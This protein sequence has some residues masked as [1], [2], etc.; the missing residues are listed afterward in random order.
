VPWTLNGRLTGVDPWRA[1]NRLA[2]A[3]FR[4]AA[5]SS[6]TAN[7]DVYFLGDSIFEGFYASAVRNGLVERVRRGLQQRY[8]PATVAGGEGYLAPMSDGM[9]TPAPGP[10]TYGGTP[11]RPAP[12][13]D[14]NG[15][16]LSGRY[17]MLDSA[18]DWAEVTFYGD[19]FAIVYT[20]GSG[21]GTLGFSVDGGAVQTHVT[22]NATLQSGK[23]LVGGALTR[24]Q[25]TVRFTASAG[26]VIVD[27]ILALDGD[28]T[29]GVRVF[30]GGHAGYD[31]ADFPGAG[32][33]NDLFRNGGTTPDL[34]CIALGAND[35]ANGIT[36]AQ[37]EINLGNI[38]DK[39][40][41]S[42]A[43]SALSSI[44]LW[45]YHRRGNI[46]DVAWQAYVDAMERVAVA[47]G[48]AFLDSHDMLDAPP[49]TGSGATFTDSV[50]PNDAGHAAY[51]EALL[52]F[53]A[54]VGEVR[55]RVGDVV[56]TG[57]PSAT[58]VLHGD[59]VWRAVSSPATPAKGLYVVRTSGSQNIPAASFVLVGL[60]NVQRNDFGA[61]W[62][63]DPTNIFTVPEDGWYAA[64]GTVRV[65]D[66]LSPTISMGIGIGPVMGDNTDFV[67]QG[68][69]AATTSSARGVMQVNHLRY[70]TAGQ[71]IRLFIY[72]DGT[73]SITSAS[74]AIVQVKGV[75]GDPGPAGPAGGMTLDTP[76]TVTGT[77]TWTD[78]FGSATATVSGAGLSVTDGVT[79][80]DVTPTGVTTTGDVVGGTVWADQVRIGGSTVDS[81][82]VDGTSAS[83]WAA[84]LLFGDGTGWGIRF[85]RANGTDVFASLTDQGV[86]DTRLLHLSGGLGALGPQFVAG[87][88]TVSGGGAGTHHGV[89][90]VEPSSTLDDQ[91]GIIVRAPDSGWGVGQPYAE[92]MAFLVLDEN[93]N[94]RW[95]V[96]RNGGTGMTGGLH[97]SPGANGA[98][99]SGITQAAWIQPLVAGIVPV[100]A[101]AVGTATDVALFRSNG[102]TTN[103]LRVKGNYGTEVGDRMTIFGD[104]TSAYV[105]HN[106]Y[107]DGT[108]WRYLKAGRAMLW[109]LADAYGA[110]Y[111]APS[112]AAGGIISWVGTHAFSDLAFSVS[113][114][115]V[116]IANSATTPAA[117]SVAV[118]E[119]AL[120]SY[121]GRLYVKENA[122]APVALDA[123][124]AY[125]YSGAGLAITGTTLVTVISTDS[126]AAGTYAFEINGTYRGSA[127]TQGLRIALLVPGTP[128]QFILSLIAATS[129]TATSNAVGIA[130][131]GVVGAGTASGG[132]ASLPFQATGSFV[133]PTGGV[134]SFRAAS[135]TTGSITIDQGTY[136]RLTR[137][138]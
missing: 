30:N 74:L 41:A 71:Q 26:L 33:W 113:A 80:T 65:P 25:H 91:T 73:F 11:G 108:N 43:G 64:H 82:R 70:W 93:N 79:T 57:T 3:R 19:Q 50:H 75:K 4:T 52:D 36:A 77:K 96:D 17:V 48:C 105:M 94:V 103:Q 59:G 104:P 97:V 111:H 22:T 6:A 130:N 83:P 37:Y 20:Q 67:W 46:T 110:H 58:T 135:H 85:L 35:V 12:G 137:I 132:T 55:V 88:A 63:A 117:Q 133:T 66:A 68:K 47:K 7:C 29:T 53:L 32:R 31:S 128:S 10:W 18:D 69:S 90:T 45:A 122:D 123:V 114:P 62:T 120:F 118:G 38:V 24:G 13:V 14:P 1:R 112:G 102:G 125:R 116:K 9:G 76:Q 100:V 27:G 56:A 134:T 106:A 21:T 95:R 87:A 86:F 92:G 72:T 42:S 81:L 129:A 121:T 5:A 124:R 23:L 40:R 131:G 115:Q 2:L 51:A 15:W 99:T 138:A 107:F 8:N 78:D 39:I 127:T 126:M 34:V 119:S 89:L 101:D 28:L 60:D 54:P 109:S 136:L 98:P 16:A 49:S 44:L 61:G 84:N